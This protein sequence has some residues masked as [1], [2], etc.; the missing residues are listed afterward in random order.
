MQPITNL[1][2]WQQVWEACDKVGVCMGSREKGLMII[3]VVVG[4]CCHKEKFSFS[5]LLFH[6]QF[7]IF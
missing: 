7:L 5:D 6:S 4:S 2:T 1:P 3:W